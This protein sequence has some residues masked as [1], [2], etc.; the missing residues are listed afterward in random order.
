MCP[1]LVVVVLGVPLPPPL[2]PVAVSSQASLPSSPAP[3]PRPTTHAGRYTDTPYVEAGKQ[4]GRGSYRGIDGSTGVLIHRAV[5]H[6]FICCTEWEVDVSN[7]TCEPKAVRVVEVVEGEEE[8]LGEEEAWLL[9]CEG[10]QGLLDLEQLA[11]LFQVTH[12]HVRRRRLPM[13]MCG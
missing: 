2:G 6:S 4:G 12:K 13:V 5:P 7:A 8:G 9:L 11:Q 3:P 10:L 1:V